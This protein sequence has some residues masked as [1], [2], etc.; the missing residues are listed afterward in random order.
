MTLLDFLEFVDEKKKLQEID[1]N[2]EAKGA[3][4]TFQENYGR[5]SLNN[6]DI[7]KKIGKGG[8]STVYLINHNDK[9]SEGIF[10]MK[11]IEKYEV[12]DKKIIENVKR[13]KEIQSEIK[14]PFLVDLRWSY[15]C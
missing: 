10:A 11:I 6:F 12:I 14:H 8:F 4:Y 5:I 3:F 15:Q 1:S 9:Q 7:I 13:E 2:N